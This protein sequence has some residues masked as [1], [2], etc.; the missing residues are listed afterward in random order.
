MSR[1]DARGLALE[2]LKKVQIPNA[3]MRANVYPFQLSGGMRQRVG[4]AMALANQPEVIIA[5]EPTTALDVT[6]QAEVLRLIMTLV[7][8]NK[9]SLIFITHDFGVIGQLCDRVM[10]MYAGQVV[11]Q[12]SAKEVLESPLHPY[13]SKLVECVPKL[14]DP[15][16]ARVEIP[17]LPPA[18]D[19]L[20]VGC[21]FAP[22]CHLATDECTR[23]PIDLNLL[24]SGR[25]ARCLKVSE[26][27]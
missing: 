3:G 5:D 11:E 20:P 12:G 2:L 17:G 6:V 13:T 25:S 8:E 22:R 23:G 10:V 9:V 24:N 1:E 18:V 4:I 26:I 16:K 19:D 21:F 14:G 27:G 7:R 15:D